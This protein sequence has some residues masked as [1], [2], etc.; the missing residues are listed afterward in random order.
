M[1][2]RDRS[3]RGKRGDKSHLALVLEGG[4]MRGVV[5][6]AM[7]SAFEERGYFAAFDSVHGSSAGACGA[8]YF[9]ARQAAFGGSIYYEDINNRKFIDLW[10]PLIGRPIMDRGF[11]VDY[12]M[13]HVKPLA[14]ERILGEESFLNIIA[15]DASS[16]ESVLFDRFRDSDHLLSVLKATICL[17][18]IAGRFAEVDGRRYLDGGLVQQ[19]AIDSAIKRGA[20]HIIVLMTRAADETERPAR[21]GFQIDTAILSAVYG[22]RMER[23]YRARNGKINDLIHEIGRGRVAMYGKTAVVDTISRSADGSRIGRLTTDGVAL[24]GAFDDARAAAFAYL[25]RSS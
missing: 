21:D 16:G 18:L 13:Q 23:V 8:A 15:T 6:V 1:R 14:F 2:L 24:R 20:T 19:I 9:A 10:R 11:L 4:G 22:K 17:P 12:V 7:A 3:A 25:D 5:S